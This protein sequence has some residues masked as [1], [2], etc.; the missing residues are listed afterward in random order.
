MHKNVGEYDHTKGGVAIVNLISSK[1]SVHIKS[2]HW[3]INA[4][5]FILDTARTNAKTIKRESANSNLTTFKFTS[6]LG[7]Q[8]VT[9]NV[10]RRYVEIQTKDI[11]KND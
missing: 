3:T 2:K 11:Q 8:L 10:E 4:L 9:L 1:F 6:E 7:K 5:A